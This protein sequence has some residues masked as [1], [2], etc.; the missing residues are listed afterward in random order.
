MYI[1]ELESV[2]TFIDVNAMTTQAFGLSAH[3]AA[4]IIERHQQSST[5]FSDSDIDNIIKRYG[6]QFVEPG[7]PILETDDDRRTE[8]IIVERDLNAL[9]FTC[10]DH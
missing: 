9:F 3:P 8:H 2:I 4:G 7:F 6:S 10:Q 5:D 1:S